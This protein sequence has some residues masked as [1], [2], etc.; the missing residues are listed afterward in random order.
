MLLNSRPVVTTGQNGSESSFRSE[1]Q[2]VPKHWNLASSQ[3]IG[4]IDQKSLK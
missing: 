1:T 2:A 3:I 4:H